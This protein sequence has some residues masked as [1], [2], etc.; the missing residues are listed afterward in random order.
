MQSFNTGSSSTALSAWLATNFANL[1]GAGAGVNNLTGLSNAQVATFFKNQFTRYGDTAA[2]VALGAALDVYA[3]TASLGGS[4]GQAAG[5]LVT[6]LGLGA[7]IFNVGLDGAAFGGFPFV[8][9]AAKW[10]ALLDA[11]P[12]WIVALVVPPALLGLLLVCWL[13]P[14]AWDDSKRFV[15]KT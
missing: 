7:E 3:T 2:L 9:H 8:L 12:T 10:N 4:A 6:A 11:A 15:G 14:P 5:F 13:S 1:F